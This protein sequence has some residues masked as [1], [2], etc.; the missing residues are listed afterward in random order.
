MTAHRQ[1]RLTM[2]VAEAA[3]VLGISRSH[4]FACI[5]RDG[6]LAGVPAISVGRRRVLS[7]QA[8]LDVTA[9]RREAVPNAG[10]RAA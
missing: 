4:A 10:R 1:P 8:I 3:R 7:R 5:Q 2:T 6:H 9:A